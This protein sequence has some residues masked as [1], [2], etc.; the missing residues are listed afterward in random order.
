MTTLATVLGATTVA[1]LA[2]P[3]GVVITV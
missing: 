2:T 1:G 3:L